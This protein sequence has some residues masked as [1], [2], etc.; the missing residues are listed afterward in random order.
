MAIA[1]AAIVGESETRFRRLEPDAIVLL[2]A[3]GGMMAAVALA[4]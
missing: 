4:G 3:Y 1:V 2:I